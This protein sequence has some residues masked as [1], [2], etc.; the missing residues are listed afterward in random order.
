MPHSILDKLLNMGNEAEN[1]KTSLAAS[2]G[3][4]MAEGCVNLS[5][6]SRRMDLDERAL[7][8]KL[9]DQGLSFRSL[10]ET[11]R[12]ALF[13]KLHAKN[14][15][16]AAIAQALAY[17]DQAAFNRAFKRWYGVPPSQYEASKA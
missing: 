3:A 8:K 10:V 13:Q 12:K 4:A 15:T 11:E 2:I 7:R 1:F 16:F 14:E 6:V 5:V 9:S 17:N